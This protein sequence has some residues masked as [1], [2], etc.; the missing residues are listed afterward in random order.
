MNAQEMIQA[1][2]RRQKEVEG[3]DEIHD[4]GHEYG[5]LMR[6]GRA[7]YLQTAQPNLMSKVDG[8]SSMWPFEKNTWKPRDA[9]SNLVRAG[10]LT[11]AERDRLDRLNDSRNPNARNTINLQLRRITGA[12][13]FIISNNQ[14]AEG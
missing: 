2:R 5:V 8:V 13:E 9:V 6:A 11:L 14:E 10:A 7:Y 4:N 1:E 12:L 3:F